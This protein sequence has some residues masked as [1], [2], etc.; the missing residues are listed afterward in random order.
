MIDSFFRTSYQTI[1]VNP[2]LKLIKGKVHPITIT[3]CGLAAG[4]LAIPAIATGYVG[5]A[6]MLILLSGYFDTLDGSLARA[7]STATPKGAVLDI[8][9][10]RIVE[11]GIILGL[12]LYDPVSRGLICLLMLASVLVC[13]TSFLVVGIFTPNNTE[14][15]FFYSPGIMERCEAFIFF[16]L[17]IVFPEMF[18]FLGIL[19]IFLVALTG[20]IRIW[21]FSEKK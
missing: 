2:S 12:Y 1:V 9:S 19:F 7:T 3:Y 13:V 16:G 10:D 14:K 17:M 11:S 15:G 8:V 4:V 6:L 18:V 5:I 21:Q 20:I